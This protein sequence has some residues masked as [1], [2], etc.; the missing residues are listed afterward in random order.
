MD[1]DEANGT[2]RPPR[3]SARIRVIRV[4]SRAN[5]GVFCQLLRTAPSLLR[6]TPRFDTY[7]AA[8]PKIL[9]LMK[10]AGGWLPRSK[11]GAIARHQSNGCSPTPRSDWNQGSCV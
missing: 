5:A 6:A 10:S 4:L 1:A 9:V 3:L 8:P 11:F 2:R 7:P